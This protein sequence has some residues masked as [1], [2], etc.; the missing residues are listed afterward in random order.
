MEFEEV[1]GPN[2]D[3]FAIKFDICDDCGCQFEHINEQAIEDR[4]PSCQSKKRIR[5]ANIMHE[6]KNFA[7]WVLWC[8]IGR[9][10]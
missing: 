9:C 10:G 8:H 2:E 7:P 5:E 3:R 4:C 1:I 6:T